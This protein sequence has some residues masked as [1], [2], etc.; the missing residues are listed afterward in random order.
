M[1]RDFLQNISRISYPGS[2]Y[3]L[4]VFLKNIRIFFRE[5]SSNIVFNCENFYRSLSL[6][7][8]SVKPD[9]YSA[10][11]SS[12]TIL[13]P[14]PNPIP[15]LLVLQKR[16]IQ[17][18]SETVYRAG[19]RQLCQG[20]LLYLYIINMWFLN[21]IVNSSVLRNWVLWNFEAASVPVI[22]IRHN[23]SVYLESSVADP[24]PPILRRRWIRS[25]RKK[26]SFVLV[27]L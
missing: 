11:L 15:I 21:V 10:T 7:L 17:Q 5:K 13:R 19:C 24:E 14:I 8:L 25:K 18:R 27:I 4:K 6:L 12:T 20:R 9:L 26:K 1:L 16:R 2:R 3:T 23:Q 22:P